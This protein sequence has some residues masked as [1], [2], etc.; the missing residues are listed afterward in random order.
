MAEDSYGCIALLPSR[1]AAA[2]DAHAV[3]RAVTPAPI[4]DDVTCVQSQLEGEINHG[5]HQFEQQ[6]N[7]SRNRQADGR[8]RENH[9]RIKKN[10]SGTPMVSSRIG[11]H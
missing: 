3:Q 2:K 1:E 11:R 9:G 10:N 6:K 8:S 7:R 5:R 4:S